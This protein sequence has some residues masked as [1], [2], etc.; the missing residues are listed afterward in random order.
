MKNIRCFLGVIAAMLSFG[1]AVQSKAAE[2]ADVSREIADLFSAFCLEK[3]PDNAALDALAK[4][5]LSTPMS[6]D[7]VKRYLHNDPGRGWYLRTKL[8][9][10]AITIEA[11]PYVTCA[12]RR[13][14]PSGLATAK[15]YIDAVGA[16]AQKHN[17]KLSNAPP[18]KAKS[19]DGADISAYPY[20]MQDSNGKSSDMFILF[21]T[22]Y[23]DQVS[24]EWRA[25][26]EGGVGVEVR[27]V[28]QLVPK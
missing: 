9:L 23:H 18:Q 26:S 11:P 25:D 14:T 27:L 17:G 20:V 8:G 13:M 7:E 19:P 28:H 5:D 6:S 3:F 2:S 16:Y 24:G 21:L 12:V 10:Y 22:N 15:P 4:S 1:L